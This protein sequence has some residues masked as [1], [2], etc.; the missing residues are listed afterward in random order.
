MFYDLIYGNSEIESI[1]EKKYPQAKF[2]DASDFIHTERFECEIPD[3]DDDEFYPFA[4]KEGF[5]RLCLKFEI[6]L[7]S[8]GMKDTHDKC[9]AM[10]DKWIEKAKD[11]GDKSDR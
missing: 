4:L 9:K 1:I 7:Q 6:T 10:L 5:A 2:K 11:G 3:V 8:I